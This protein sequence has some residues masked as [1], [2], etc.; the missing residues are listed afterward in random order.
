MAFLMLRTMQ[1]ARYAPVNLGHFGL[2]VR[3]YTHFTSPIRRYPDL[4]VHRLLRAARRPA[5]TAR[6]R[7]D[8]RGGPAGS[9]AAHLGEGAAGRRGRA[10]AACSGRRSA[11]WPTRSGRSSTATSRASRRSGCSSS[12]S[13]TTSR[14]SC[15]SRRM[16]DDYYRFLERDAHAARREHGEGVPAGRPGAGAASSAWTWKAADRFGA[17]RDP[18]GGPPGRAAARAARPPKPKA[19]PRRPPTVRKRQRAGKNERRRRRG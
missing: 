18:R 1:K 2:A 6:E 14:A 11:S 3:S 9:R 17:R 10:R 13:S 15:T 5:L 7:E 16:A 19:G 12:W 4:V 8:L